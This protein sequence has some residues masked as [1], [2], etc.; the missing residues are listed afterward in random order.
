MLLLRFQDIDFIKKLIVARRVSTKGKG[1]SI[2]P[3]ATARL[4]A[5]LRRR[6]DGW[7][8]LARECQQELETIVLH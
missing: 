6:E 4:D 7:K 5:A 3:I 2:V 1:N 8:H